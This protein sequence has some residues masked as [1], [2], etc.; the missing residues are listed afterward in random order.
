MRGAPGR[1][2]PRR[3]LTLNGVTHPLATWA[4]V[5]GM[6]ASTIAYRL[7]HGQTVEEALRPVPSGFVQAVEAYLAA[8]QEKER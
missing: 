2:K 7:N 1:P 5:V 6:P 8:H 3:L 4:R